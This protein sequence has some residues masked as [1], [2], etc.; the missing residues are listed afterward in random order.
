MYSI[1]ILILLIIVFVCF[2]NKKNIEH[3]SRYFGGFFGPN[4]YRNR[5]SNRHP[6]YIW[7]ALAHLYAL[8]NTVRSEP[9]FEF[10]PPIGKDTIRL[11]DLAAEFLDGRGRLGF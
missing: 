3:F 5:H 9:S 11:T 1:I 6:R 2:S 7:S 8:I 4:R 10:R